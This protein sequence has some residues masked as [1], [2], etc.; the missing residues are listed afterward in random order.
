LA[1]YERGKSSAIN[2]L[3]AAAKKK[4]ATSSATDCAFLC[5][6]PEASAF[7]AVKGSAFEIATPS[8]NSAF[9][10]SCIIAGQFRSGVSAS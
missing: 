1:R 7:S 2:I 3:P 10:G 5:D 9:A 6:I 4:F 8:A